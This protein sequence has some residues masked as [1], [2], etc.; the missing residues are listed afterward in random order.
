M[1][2]IMHDWSIDNNKIWE[3]ENYA[4]SYH[5]HRCNIQGISFIDDGEIHIL[6][7]KDINLT[8]EEIIIKNIIE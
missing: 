3:I 8:C 4:N 6:W 7:H 2:K 1:I 5:C